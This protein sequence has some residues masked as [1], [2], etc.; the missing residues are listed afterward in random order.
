VFNEL[1]AECLRKHLPGMITA[2]GRIDSRRSIM[3]HI[4]A[5]VSD[6]PSSCVRR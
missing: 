3:S 1:V 6:L 5:F 2:D 4:N